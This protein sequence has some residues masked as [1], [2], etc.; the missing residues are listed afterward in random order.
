[1]LFS[2]ATWSVKAGEKVCASAGILRVRTRVVC[3]GGGGEEA[4]GV[5][6]C[7]CVCVGLGG[8]TKRPLRCH[9]IN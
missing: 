6:G 8:D 4:V 7:A 1:M 2:E 9:L 5:W 3:M